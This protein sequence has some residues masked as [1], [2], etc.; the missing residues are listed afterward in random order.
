MHP[1]NP[2]HKKSAVKKPKHICPK[3]GF[4][5][6]ASAIYC[7]ICF[8]PLNPADCSVKQPPP[9]TPQPKTKQSTPAVDLKQELRQPSTIAG[10]AVLTLA[11]SLWINYFLQGRARNITSNNSKNNIS[12]YDSMKEVKGVPSGLYSYGGALYFA[13]LIA[14]GMNDAMLEEHSNFNLRYTKPKDSDLS[15]DKGIKMLLDGELSFAFNGRP[16]LDREYAQASLRGMTLQQ[17]PIA[18]DGIVFFGNRNNMVNNLNMKQVRDIFAGKIVNWSQLGG[19]NLPITPIMISPQNIEVLGLNDLNRIPQRTE[20][21]DNYTLAMRQAIAIPGSIAFASASIIKEQQ[22]IKIFSLAADNS[23]NYVAPLTFS[24]Q[25]KL[26]L[27][28]NGI[29]PL[30]RRLFLVIRQ[31][32]TPDR[33]AGKAYAE[34]LLSTQGQEIVEKSGFV[35]LHG[36]R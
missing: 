34:M 33:L 11:I 29:Y 9:A 12:L 25:P 6:C 36:D 19:E 22:L 4:D 31:D 5:N 32:G 35:P 18:I 20:Y 30:T 13:S 10:L 28:K 23:T 8:Y 7:E 1:T 26:E 27:F 16:L 21:S 17:V 24:R 2:R 15:Y 3:C 14:N